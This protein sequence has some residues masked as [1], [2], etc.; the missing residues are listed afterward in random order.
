MYLRFNLP[1]HIRLLLCALFLCGAQRLAAV[2][3]LSTGSA[4]VPFMGWTNAWRLGNDEVELFVV[5]E[6][7]AR[8]VG[9][10]LLN[11][12]NVVDVHPHYAGSVRAFTPPYQTVPYGGAKLWAAPQGGA[13]WPAAGWPPNAYWENGRAYCASFGPRCIQLSSP[14]VATSVLQCTRTLL[15]APTGSDVLVHQRLRNVSATSVTSALWAINPLPLPCQVIAPTGR[16]YWGSATTAFVVTNGVLWKAITT[17]DGKKLFIAADQPWLAGWQS[18]LLW[19]MWGD[20]FDART[21]ATNEASVEIW[22][23][24]TEAHGT[25]ELELQGP[26]VALKPGEHT[27]YRMYWRLVLLAQP[28]LAAALDVVRTAGLIE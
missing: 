2:V 7:G 21:A 27:D 22:Y 18:N 5:P 16:Y 6:I 28:T 26:A 14:H 23:G 19:L 17:F 11:G 4:S 8:V 15:L 10:R 13:G 25:A 1:R 9:Y 12:T 20:T 24:Q 3:T